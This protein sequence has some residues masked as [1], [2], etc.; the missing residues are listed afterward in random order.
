MRLI[1]ESKQCLAIT[2]NMKYLNVATNGVF[3]HY[4]VLLLFSH[5][6]TRP[7]YLWNTSRENGQ[8][9]SLL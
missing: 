1:N 9:C 3:L 2:A 5:Y 8:E 7:G 6:V 4:L